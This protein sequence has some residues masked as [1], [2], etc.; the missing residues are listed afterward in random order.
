RLLAA[1]G[2]TTVRLPGDN[3]LSVVKLEAAGGLTRIAQATPGQA[4][5]GFTAVVH[6]LKNRPAKEVMEPLKVFMSKPG[7]SV[8]LLGEDLL[9]IMDL[10]P[11]VEQTVALLERIDSPSEVASVVEVKARHLSAA[12][13]ATIVSQVAAK[14]D[15]VSGSK[16]P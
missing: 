14:R 12:Q 9:L 15:L 6:R 10:T 16:V 3:L 1:R 8:S 11:R 5:A 2:F 13:L 4:P 7:G